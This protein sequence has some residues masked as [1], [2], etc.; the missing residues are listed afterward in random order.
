MYGVTFFLQSLKFDTCMLAA[1]MVDITT[2]KVPIV[3]KYSFI[4]PTD[5]P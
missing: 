2:L 4:M 5:Y 1:G 3:C